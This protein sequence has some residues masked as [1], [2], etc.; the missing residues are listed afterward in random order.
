MGIGVGWL[1][2][3]VGQVDVTATVA[4]IEIDRPAEEVFAYVTDPRHFPEWQRNVGEMPANMQS[5][6]QSLEQTTQS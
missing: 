1:E 5:Q 6:K 4:T 2:L 3:L